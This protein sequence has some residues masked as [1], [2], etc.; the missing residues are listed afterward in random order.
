MWA[1]FCFYIYNSSV[2]VII[3]KN[4]VPVRL[5]NTSSLTMC[6]L[7]IFANFASGQRSAVQCLSFSQPSAGCKFHSVGRQPDANCIRLVA[8][9]YKIPK[10]INSQHVF[11]DK[12]LAYCQA[13]SVLQAPWDDIS[14]NLS[15]NRRNEILKYQA[16]HLQERPYLTVPFLAHPKRVRQ[17]L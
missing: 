5:Q 15:T 3:Y 1:I 12:G 7:H 16:A 10:Y 8:M 17:S 13:A 4:V 11:Q 2:H 9:Q 14:L 6:Q